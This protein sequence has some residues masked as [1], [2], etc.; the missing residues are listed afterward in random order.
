MSN[1]IKA[2]IG[3][4]LQIIGEI[5]PDSVSPAQLKAVA[6][7]LLS[8][9]T[10]T[11]TKVAT[12]EKELYD[13]KS[14]MQSVNI[15]QEA[16]QKAS[17]FGIVSLPKNA[18]SGQFRDV[19]VKGNQY[20]NLVKNG[21]F[22]NGLTDWQAYLSNI[23][24]E[25]G[26]GYFT[27]TD[28]NGSIRQSLTLTNGR[29][30]FV[31][32][33]VKANSNLVVL[34]VSGVALSGVAQHS[35]SGNFERLYG[36]IT[37][38]LTTGGW[39]MQVVDGRTSG[40][41]RVDV[42][43]FIII[44]LTAHGLDSLT[45]EQCNQ[46]FPYW[47]DGTKST[48]A[49]LRLKS[50]GKNLFDSELED[51]SFDASTGMKIPS[52][53]VIRNKN[54]IK[55]VGG[56]SFY[57][58][59]YFTL[60]DTIII[61]PFDANKNF[62]GMSRRIFVSKAGGSFTL[63][64]DVAYINIAFVNLSAPAPVK[65]DVQLETGTAAT[66][67]EPYTENTTY[68]IATDE[69]DNIHQ[70]NTDDFIDVISKKAVIGDTEIP[71]QASGVLLSRPSGTIYVEPIIADAGIYTNKMTI[72]NPN[73][74]IKR[75]DRLSKVDYATGEET[76]LDV[77]QAVIAGD[78][79]SFTHPG[80]NAGDIVFFAYEYEYDGTQPEIEVEYYDSRYVVK[81][82]V[83]GKF[84]KWTVAVANGLPSITLTEV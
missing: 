30:Y 59:P 73:I 33:R 80:L 4:P 34:N 23:G 7:D 52:D 71:I 54:L 74:P 28:V 58:K 22:A 27:A 16:T 76:F 50:V 32:A 43:D 62:I 45:A 9:K 78:G 19:R 47:F 81:D 55:V 6:D 3:Q 70:L 1:E 13:Y 49:A 5:T 84:Y 39:T 8:H 29:K 41:S 57:I 79:K 67:Y 60:T 37:W 11:A 40:W 75:L 18:A 72:L 24:V 56:N 51:G 64:N 35:G 69:D 53:K 31:A 77:N 46:R 21:S 38:T 42:D 17:G 26:T 82:S 36:I 68:I 83:T 12:V 10:E 48:P 14:A 15:N 2:V 25:N 66:P 44:D 20:T 65:G 63:A 61:Y